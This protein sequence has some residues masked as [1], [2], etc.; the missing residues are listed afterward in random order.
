M[1]LLPPQNWDTAVSMVQRE[2]TR[3]LALQTGPRATGTNRYNVK[4]DYSGTR[5]APGNFILPMGQAGEQPSLEVVR[6][7]ISTSP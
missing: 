3:R 7:Q 6:N 2:W 5:C 1:T 4:T